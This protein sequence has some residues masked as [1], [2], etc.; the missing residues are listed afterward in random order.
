MTELATPLHDVEQVLEV[1]QAKRHATYGTHKPSGVD[2]LGEIPEHWEV[3]RL[4]F[5]ARP[6]PSPAEITGLSAGDEIS[7]VPMDAVCEHGG[8]RLDQTRPLE[9]VRSGFTYFREG[10]VVVAKITPCFENGK[11]SIAHGLTHGVGFGTTELHVIRAQRHLN[12]HFLF[13]LT[14]SHAFRKLG[15]SEMYGA[16]GQKRVPN[17]F[18][19]DFPTPLP[20]VDD[21]QAIAR[22]LDEQTKKI[23]D[24]IEAKRTLLNLLKEKRQAVITHA[25]TKGLDPNAK[26]TPSGIDWLGDVPEHWNVVPLRHVC[27]SVQ[28]GPFGSQLHQSDYLPGGIPLINPVHLVSGRVAPDE[29]SAV[30][31]ATQQRLSRHQVVP[32]DILFARRGEIGRC[33]MVGEDQGGWLCGTGCMR[34]RLSKGEPSYY[35]LMF[36]SHGFAATLTVN[37]VGTTMLNINNTVLM[38]M[39]VPWPPLHEQRAIVE[40]VNETRDRIQS[41][42]NEVERAIEQLWA[43]RSA[44]ISAAV[45]GKIDVRG[46]TS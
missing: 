24:L 26:L 18:V 22:F 28:T 12:T 7:F 27:E 33:G 9:D 1:T 23:D 43:Y 15:A 10:D 32:G 41:L 42:S 40:W 35:N 3:K 46:G 20:P 11:G 37:A 36:N 6:N 34:L 39:V 30:D 17:D 38:R 16:G 29:Q 14:I 5:V 4:K 21:Q 13:Y 8:L 45:T 19:R 44:L 31:E 2:W 25:V